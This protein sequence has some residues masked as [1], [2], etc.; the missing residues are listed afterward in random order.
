M[1]PPSSAIEHEYAFEALLP[2]LECEAC[3]SPTRPGI[4]PN[5]L[6]FSAHL[7]PHGSNSTPSVSLSNSNQPVPTPEE[8]LANLPNLLPLTAESQTELIVVRSHHTALSPEHE[9]PNLS[10]PPWSNEPRGSILRRE[11]LFSPV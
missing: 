7:P 9:Q 5:Q 4:S 10:T 11:I 8:R 1:L 3:T 2:S 6:L